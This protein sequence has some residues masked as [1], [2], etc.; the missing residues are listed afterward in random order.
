MFFTMSRDQWDG[1]VELI[2]EDERLNLDDYDV[3]EI[4]ETEPAPD[5]SGVIR[6]EPHEIARGSQR[7]EGVIDCHYLK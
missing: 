3:Y 2:E 5:D 7:Q 6:S 4:D 1:D